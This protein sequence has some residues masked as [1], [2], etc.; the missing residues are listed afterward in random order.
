MGAAN[1]NLIAALVSVR[2]RFAGPQPDPGIGVAALLC[3]LHLHVYGEDL[4]LRT[5]RPAPDRA[6]QDTDKSPDKCSHRP[7]D[8]RF[9]IPFE[10]AV[11][12]DAL[13]NRRRAPKP[14]S[15]KLPPAIRNAKN[16][17]T[18][19]SYRYGTLLGR[20]QSAEFWDNLRVVQDLT[21]SGL[22]SWHPI[23]QSLRKENEEKPAQG[24]VAKR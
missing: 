10:A 1:R 22:I 17:G 23:A 14:R 16:S 5:L 19:F 20:S 15:R 24:K 12:L 3:L 13:A 21:G 6:D 11:H 9:G 2:H 8:T 7:D 4:V 18:S